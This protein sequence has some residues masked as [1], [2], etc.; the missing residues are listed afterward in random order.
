ML[1]TC[2]RQHAAS[3]ASPAEESRR[4]GRLVPPPVQGRRDRDKDSTLARPSNETQPARSAVWSPPRTVRRRARVVRELLDVRRRWT[5]TLTFLQVGT[6]RTRNNS[7]EGA[8][9]E[10]RKGTETAAAALVAASYFSEAE[11]R[12]RCA[13]RPKR[14]RT[15]SFA[16]AQRSTYIRELARRR[17]LHPDRPL[18]HRAARQEWAH[19]RRRLCR[20]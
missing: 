20:R 2:A 13:Q 17:L 3:S 6:T 16:T 14:R 11:R 9:E 15:R 8:G 4:Q 7:G 10:A 18:L 1:R 19:P 5:T 12:K